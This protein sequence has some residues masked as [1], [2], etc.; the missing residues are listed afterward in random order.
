[1]DAAAD[2]WNALDF[3]A[4]GRVAEELRDPHLKG[5]DFSSEFRKHVLWALK[6]RRVQ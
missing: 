1:M 4:Y 5:I 6:E 3:A 2:G